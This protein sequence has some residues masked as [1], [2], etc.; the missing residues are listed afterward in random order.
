MFR[1]V[2]MTCTLNVHDVFDEMHVMV[3]MSQ[4][5]SLFKFYVRGIVFLL[6]TISENF[7]KFWGEA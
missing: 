3:R 7:N 6:F 5:R 4:D 2:F 1:C